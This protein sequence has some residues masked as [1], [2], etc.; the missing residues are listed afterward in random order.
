MAHPPDQTK[1]RV[2][3]DLNPVHFGRRESGVGE[4]SE[5]GNPSSDS[6]SF[7]EAGPSS[8]ASHC[9]WIFQSQFLCMKNGSPAWG[10][11]GSLQG[12]HEKAALGTRVCST[13]NN[14]Y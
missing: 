5:S 4:G 14:H 12:F 13:A 3:L 9:P 1:G 10:L 11:T 8:S 6:S 2:A 7:L